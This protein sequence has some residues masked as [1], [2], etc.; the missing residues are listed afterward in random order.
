MLWIIEALW[1]EPPRDAPARGTPE[2]VEQWGEYTKEPTPCGFPYRSPSSPGVAAFLEAVPDAKL[3]DSLQRARGRGRD[4]YPIH[5]LW[6]T[7]LLT[8]VLRHPTIDACR[9]RST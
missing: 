2:A 3:L 7:L 1:G 6:G 9:G 4:D 5:V 8:I